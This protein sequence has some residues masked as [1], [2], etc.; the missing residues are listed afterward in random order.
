MFD[1]TKE[2]RLRAKHLQRALDETPDTAL[3]RLRRLPEYRAANDDALRAVAA[4]IPRKLCLAVVA[5]EAGFASWSHALQVIQGEGGEEDFGDLLYP[6]GGD[7]HLNHWFARHE[8]ARA[9]RSRNGGYLLGYR[10]QA[11]IAE[12]GFIMTML[13]LDPD[14]DD[15]RAIGWDWVRPAEP[16]ARQRLYAAILAGLPRAA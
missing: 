16:K 2:L 10:R 5:R 11:F 14:H 13:G 7:A 9:F 6:R 8:D 12:R 15:W 3:A 4:D 1:P